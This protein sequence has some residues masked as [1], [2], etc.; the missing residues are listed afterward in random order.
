MTTRLIAK[1]ASTRR[2]I[3]VAAF[4]GVL[5]LASACSSSGSGSSNTPAS[6]G[7]SGAA[8]TQ[9]LKITTLGLCNE[10]P[11]FWSEDKGL[12]KSHGL[13]VQTV[14]STGG[15]AAL[16]ALQSG[17]VDLAFTNPFSTM[18]AISH[19]LKL[20][21]IATAYGTPTSQS[22]ATNAV[23]VAK[24]SPIT[25]AKGLEGK[26]IG[27]NEIG[28]INQIITSQW[29]KDEGA[30]PSKVKFVALPFTEL[31]SAVASGKVAASQVPAQNVSP[32][33]GLKS[34]ADPYVEV[35]KGKSLVFAGYVATSGVASSKQDALK[36]FQQTLIE[37]DAQ[38]S[39]PS[40]AKERHQI[41]SKH[42]KQAVNVLDQ[43]KE[44]PYVATVDTTALSRMGEILKEQGIVS[45]PPSP[46]SYVPSW[47]V[48]AGS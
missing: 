34:L 30:D 27:V 32:S 11:I 20:Q 7:S 22:D 4:A 40:A 45:N 39:K 21:W 3:G 19:G 47:V 12:F 25:D 38:L 17:D 26:T 37:A 13:N 41:E 48:K 10:I 15:A 43:V 28:G 8:G 42:C 6:T 46:D 23:A 14:T 33:L 24:N 35:G 1:H 44:N 5:V 2:L 36:R 31:A 9:T 16:T 29:L 18:I